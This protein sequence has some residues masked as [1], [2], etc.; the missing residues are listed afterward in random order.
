[1]QCCNERKLVCIAGPMGVVETRPYSATEEH[2]DMMKTQA[3]LKE[4]EGQMNTAMVQPLDD[5][6]HSTKVKTLN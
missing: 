2:K 5:V 6:S 1:M 3:S 4:K